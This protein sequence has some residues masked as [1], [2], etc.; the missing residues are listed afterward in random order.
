MRPLRAAGVADEAAGEGAGDRARIGARIV[1]QPGQVGAF[2]R[3]GQADG[4]D[5]CGDLIQFFANRRA[6]AR[7]VARACTA[8]R[9]VGLSSSA[10]RS[11]RARSSSTGRTGAR[12]ATAPS[13]TSRG[14]SG[15]AEDRDDEGVGTGDKGRSPRPS[16]AH[17]W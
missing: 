12:C 2:R 13:I 17:S 8:S 6:A 11:C 9:S 16:Q 10:S 15:G 3:G 1:R 7:W 5:S 4:R 14:T